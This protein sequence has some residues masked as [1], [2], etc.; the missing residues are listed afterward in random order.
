MLS[1]QYRLKKNTPIQELRRVGR[2]WHNHQLV[3]VARSNDRHQ[4]RFAFS[5]SRRIGQAVVR[6]RIKR[7]MRESVRRSLPRIRAGWD[8]LL[9]ARRP[10]RT[11]TFAQ[12]DRAVTALLQCA[13]LL[14]ESTGLP[15][16]PNQPANWQPNSPKASVQ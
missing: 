15:V 2:S 3:L 11:A 5:V 16:Q 1:K 10:T 13:Q 14:L 7:L 4:S 8:I 12:I 9:I 6:N